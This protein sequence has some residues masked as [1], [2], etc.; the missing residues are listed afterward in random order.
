MDTIVNVGVTGAL[1]V[2]VVLLLPCIYR[3][4]KGPSAADRLQVS[5]TMT[6]LLIGIIVVLALLRG[7]RMYVDVALALA[8]F[9]FI[10]TLALARYISEGRLF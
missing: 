6:T 3:L 9:S 4:W 2:L 5:D 1:I 10:G 7:D 8:A